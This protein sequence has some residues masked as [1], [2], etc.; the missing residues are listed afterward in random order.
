MEMDCYPEYKHHIHPNHQHYN[1]GN[2]ATNHPYYAGNYSSSS[3]RYAHAHTPFESGQQQNWIDGYARYNQGQHHLNHH[4]NYS[5]SFNGHYGAT[6]EQSTGQFYYQNAHQNSAGYYGNNSYESYRNASTS[7]YHYPYGTGYHQTPSH[8]SQ[9]FPSY[10]GA[11]EQFNNRY[12]P[13]PP[14]SVTPTASQRDPYSVTQANEPTP[15]YASMMERNLN[16]KHNN[17][18]LPNNGVKGSQ[19]VPVASSPQS[20]L[21]RQST[22]E[23]VE[24]NEH[25]MEVQ[26]TKGEESSH[27]SPAPKSELLKEENLNDSAKDEKVNTNDGENEAANVENQSSQS[28]LFNENGDHNQLHSCN[29]NLPKGNSVN[30]QELATDVENS[31]ATGK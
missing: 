25:K 17:E 10:N 20:S 24:N 30:S 11:A 18:R 22:G 19:S 6:R 31:L 16:D 1:A 7:G 14:P 28:S 4:G 13:T 3:M 9:Y 5:N 21:V 26:Q 15:A 27:E 2:A 8:P 29:E 23:N 12:Y